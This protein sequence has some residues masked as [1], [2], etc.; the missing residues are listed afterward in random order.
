MRKLVAHVTVVE[1]LLPWSR[2]LASVTPQHK[3]A[4]ARSKLCLRHVRGAAHH[5]W[6]LC[7]PC[8]AYRPAGR[9]R[10]AIESRLVSIHLP[11]RWTCSCSRP[12]RWPVLAARRKGSGLPN[13]VQPDPTLHGMHHEKVSP[14]IM[15]RS[16][17]A[18]WQAS[19]CSTEKRLACC[20]PRE[21]ICVD[22]FRHAK[23]M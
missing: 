18:L 9:S 22:S 4:P 17:P 12:P 10:V 23:W 2:V 14:R 5:R 15:K 6:R 1:G 8:R 3:L 7:W 16:H 11:R 20:S 21:D 13:T 19:L